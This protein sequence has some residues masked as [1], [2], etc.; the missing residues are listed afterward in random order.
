MQMQEMEDMERFFAAERKAGRMN[1]GTELGWR[2]TK[3]FSHIANT[4]TW[5]FGANAMTAIDGFTKSF[6][7]SGEARNRAYRS[8]L[9]KL[10]EV[11]PDEFKR[12][13]D[14]KQRDLRNDV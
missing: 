2:A 12:L 8:L 9:P 7:A 3:L 10:T 11:S 14:A 5:R 13:F 4:N 1:L 6:I